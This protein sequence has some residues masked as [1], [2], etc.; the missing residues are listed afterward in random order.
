MQ[1]PICLAL[2]AVTFRHCR[3]LW[4]LPWPLVMAMRSDLLSPSPT[5]AMYDC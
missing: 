4:P 2:E 1:T 3:V 5:G